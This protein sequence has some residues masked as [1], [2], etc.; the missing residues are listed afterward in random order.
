MLS[1]ES[2]VLNYKK[3]LTVK[4]KGYKLYEV[5]VRP[6]IEKVK[7]KSYKDQIKYMESQLFHIEQRINSRLVSHSK[8]PSKEHLLIKSRSIIERH[9]D[10][11]S[12][13]HAHSIYAIHPEV[14][15]KFLKNFSFNGERYFVTN[16]IMNQKFYE[17]HEIECQEITDL[18]NFIMYMFKNYREDLDPDGVINDYFCLPVIPQPSLRNFEMK[19][20]LTKS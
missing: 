17:L 13:I 14:K 12:L 18:E 1:K 4:F 11:T 3:D 6:K 16:E 15:D 20:Q 2:L 10:D 19:A 9:S 5:T 8:N 7:S